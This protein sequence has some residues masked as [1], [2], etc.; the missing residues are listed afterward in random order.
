VAALVLSGAARYA[1]W[2]LSGGDL[3][4]GPAQDMAALSGV[5]DATAALLV[6]ASTGPSP[7]LRRISRAD[8]AGTGFSGITGIRAL[9]R[10][11]GVCVVR[12]G[13]PP[14]ARWVLVGLES[15]AVFTGKFTVVDGQETRDVRAGEIAAVSDPAATLHLQAGNDSALAIGFAAPSVVVAL[16]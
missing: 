5:E 6:H 10:T 9:V 16:G 7:P 1:D 11:P 3:L 12:L 4:L 8:L 15:F 13:P 2:T 14:G